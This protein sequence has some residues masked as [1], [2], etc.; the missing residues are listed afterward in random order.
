MAFSQYLLIWSGNLP[1]EIVW[2]LHRNAGGWQWIGGGLGLLYFAVPFL[3]L[4]PRE[5]KRDPVRLRRVALLV[6]AMHF[7]NHYWLIVP[8]FVPG[9]LFLHWM[10][11]AAWVGIGGIWSALFV[12]QLQSRPLVALHRV[13]V[14][15]EVLHHA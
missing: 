3:L 15:E 1:E 13:A 7:V 14:G 5:R 10:D 2:Y 4:L 9:Q 6:L 12:R 8:S 11:V